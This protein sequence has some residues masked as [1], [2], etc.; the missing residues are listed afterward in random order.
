MLY[1]SGTHGEA[2]ATAAAAAAFKREEEDVVV[3]LP[4][5]WFQS[6]DTSF[7]APNMYK[8]D[9][10]M[11]LSPQMVV[12]MLSV[13][14]VIRTNVTPSYTTINS[15]TKLYVYAWNNSV[16]IIIFG[17]KNGHTWQQI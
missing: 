12:T 14:Q 15:I 6:D 17:R 2:T 4:F 3:L 7:I 11:G 16:V 5:V 8:I 1:T 10:D 9:S 13:Y